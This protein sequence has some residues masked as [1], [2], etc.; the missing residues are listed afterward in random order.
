MK[1]TARNLSPP[2][3]L[4]LFFPS[5][6]GK[7]KKKNER[8]S[9]LLLLFLFVWRSAEFLSFSFHQPSGSLKMPFFCFVFL[10]G[11]RL[12]FFHYF[13]LFHKL[14]RK[15]ITTFRLWRA[16]WWCSIWSSQRW[17]SFFDSSLIG[18][19]SSI[20]LFLLSSLCGRNLFDRRSIFSFFSFSAWRPPPHRKIPVE[21]E[22]C[23]A[24]AAY[25]NWDSWWFIRLLDSGND[26]RLARC[27][28]RDLPARSASCLVCS[29][30]RCRQ[31]SSRR[32]R[33]SF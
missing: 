20:F 9:F 5:F 30:C 27:F 10:I 19:Q 6:D 29:F 8:K 28:V 12:L 25:L 3:F 13:V 22:A 15:K 32:A 18:S 1:I 26:S 33:Q 21:N 2:Y 14:H 16:I 7:K 4:S 23:V 24:V 31:T 11:V 17:L